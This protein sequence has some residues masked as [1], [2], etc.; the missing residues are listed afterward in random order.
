MSTRD[1]GLDIGSTSVR[2]VEVS[3]NGKSKPSLLRFHE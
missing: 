2:A 1:V 3:A